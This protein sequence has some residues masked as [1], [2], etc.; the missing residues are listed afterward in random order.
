MQ[1]NPDSTKQAVEIIFSCKKKR[2]NHP[3]LSFGGNP[4]VEEHSQ[5][6]LGLTLHK[7]LSFKLHIYEKTAKAKKV[8]GSLKRL[9]GIYQPKRLNQ[10]TNP[11]SDHILIIVT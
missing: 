8:L 3:T 10:F 4:V 2:Q 7:S 5:K 1:F 6:H 9:P 11:L